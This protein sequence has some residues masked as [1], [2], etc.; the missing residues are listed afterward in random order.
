MWKQ[1]EMGAQRQ[2]S[3]EPV[4]FSDDFSTLNLGSGESVRPRARLLGESE[5]ST[6][7]ETEASAC[8]QLQGQS[9]QFY[10]TSTVKTS[11]ISSVSGSDLTARPDQKPEI[12]E[13]SIRTDDELQNV[14]IEPES[15]SP[16]MS[17]SS[18][19]H[20]FFEVEESEFRSLPSYHVDNY[21]RR[22][23][24]A[25][26]GMQPEEKR[27]AEIKEIHREAG[28]IAQYSSKSPL[29][30]YQRSISADDSGVATCAGQGKRKRKRRADYPEPSGECQSLPLDLN[31]VAFA[32]STG[33]PKRVRSSD[34]T[35]PI[36]GQEKS[37]AETERP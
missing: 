12:T 37:H 15:I 26:Q 17:E 5:Q 33:M 13:W 3:P 30:Q 14:R 28:L 9:G 6:F 11:D 31:A 16:L 34:E 21:P 18:T 2:M 8:S 19:V 36:E 35:L 7:G 23:F 29:V 22:T 1:G 20:E 27:S 24:F 4:V 10:S 32:S 25:G